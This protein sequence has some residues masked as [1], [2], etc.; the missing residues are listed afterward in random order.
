MNKVKKYIK[1]DLFPIFSGLLALAS[2]LIFRYFE[3][4]IASVVLF[5]FALLISGYKVFFDAIRGILRRDFLDEK[6]LMSIASIGALIIGEYTEGVAVMIFF[7]VG[8]YFEH[9]AIRKSRSSI[10][11]LMDINPDEAHIIKNGKEETVDAD[12]VEADDIILVRPGERVPVDCTVISG[13]SDIDTSAMTGEAAPRSVS[14]DDILDSGVVVLNGVLTC[15]AIRPADESAASRVLALVE[16]ASERKSKEEAFI[17]K[18]SRYY[19]PIVVAAAILLAVFPPLFDWLSWGDAVYRAL[20]FLVISCPCALVISV[21]MSFFGGI[22]AAAS[23]G[24]LFKGGN[25]FS[26]VANADTIAFDK[27]GTLT[28]GKFTII[29][30][31][32]FGVSEEEVIKYAASAEYGSNHPIAAALKTAAAPAKPEFVNEIAGKGVIA[33]VE[34]HTVAV[35]GEALMVDLSIALE[36]QKNGVLVALDGRHIGTIEL[37]DTIKPEVC[38]ALINLNSLGVCRSVILSGDKYENAE[39]IANKIGIREVKAELTPIQKYEQLE[40]LIDRSKKGVF[41]V[42]D[43]INDAPS[44]ARADVGIAMGAIGSDS[45]IEAADIVIMSDNLSKIPE[46]VKIARKTVRIA[47][48]NIIFA[49]GIKLAVMLLGVLNIANMWLAVFADVGVSVLAIL[50]AMRTMIGKKKTI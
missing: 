6:F 20:I 50:N 15:R 27:T 11:E 44:L 31:H 41:F 40:A 7:L 18:F 17:T 1:H 29:K 4:K 3:F 45:A 5:V 21:P 12:E 32:S 8:E 23:R 33:T 14:E 49:I 34:N 30:T 46:A 43:G 13:I 42:G 22:G 39:R 10:R 36:E 2:A 25:I 38:E 24:I 48:E 37:S 47:K 9:R 19:T 35:G 16:E 28:S 26:H